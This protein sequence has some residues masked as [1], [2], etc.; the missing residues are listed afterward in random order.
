MRSPDELRA[1]VDRALALP[2]PTGPLAWV[3]TGPVEALIAVAVD[4]P[5]ATLALVDAH[6]RAPGAAHRPAAVRALPALAAAVSP[7]AV[8]GAL[9]LL[10]ELAT[11]AER[12]DDAVAAAALDALA[13]CGALDD[14]LRPARAAATRGLATPGARAALARLDP[15]EA[16]RWL[17]ELAA[18][19][20][21]VPADAEAC[22]RALR[23]AGGGDGP[24][25]RAAIARLDATLARQATLAA[26]AA[27]RQLAAV[28]ARTP[29]SGDGD[30]GREAHAPAGGA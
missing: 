20:A 2:T 8:A 6:A 7:D 1:A 25:A 9:A 10:V 14:G 15:L 30:D 22:A 23:G 19:P 29:D 4:A 16:R 24:D 17:E 3:R 26:T 28:T 12:A 11:D 21:P 27:R 13:T 5:A 18:A